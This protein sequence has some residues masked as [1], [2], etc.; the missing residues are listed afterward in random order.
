MVG[1]LAAT[2][3]GLDPAQLNVG[4]PL[5]FEEK[6][7]TIS[8]TFS[9][10]GATFE[11]EVWCRL[12]DLQQVLKRQDLSLV[13][14]KLAPTA[15]IQE[16]DLFC[17]ER[18][19]LELQALHQTEYFDSLRADYAPV[20]WLSWFIVL[21]VSGAGVFVG[22]NTMYGAVVGRISELATLQTLGFSRRAAILSVLQ[23]GALLSMSGAMIASLLAL[24]LVNGA[25]VRFTMGAFTLQM[26]GITLLTGNLIA[27]CLGIGGAIPPA[28]R[29]CRLSV[30]DSLKAV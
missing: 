10:G 27:L 12:D 7:W 14:V 13:A 26:D 29:I 22:L 5:R 4:E 30:V 16:I 15:Q 24:I 23:E 2:K 11:S 20:R 18:L 1:R 21:L 3:L 9:A 19:D 8:A 17:K 28:I 6:D 25:A